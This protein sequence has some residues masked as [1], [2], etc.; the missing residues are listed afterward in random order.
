RAPRQG[1]LRAC[2][3]ALSSEALD[4]EGRAAQLHP[5]PAIWQAQPGRLSQERQPA[6]TLWRPQPAFGDTA[7]VLQAELRPSKNGA[8]IPRGARAAAKQ[9]AQQQEWQVLDCD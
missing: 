1:G 2:A 7:E 9:K 3:G 5:Q 4:F 8:E 6:P